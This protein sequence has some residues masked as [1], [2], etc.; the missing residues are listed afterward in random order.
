MQRDVFAMKRLIIQA[1]AWSMLGLIAV[2]TLGPLSYRPR[3]APP[4]L[5]R[6][7]AYFVL[8]A[9]FSVAYDRPR[10]VAVALSIL[11]IGLELG[12]FLAP[13]RDAGLPDAVAK[14][15]GAVAGVAL[16]AVGRAWLTR[17]TTPGDLNLA[18]D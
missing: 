8:G 17:R 14:V 3:M 5:E 18:P 12:Q 9:L 15:L 16:I 1:A 7:G 2:W 4:Q 13:G 11:A 6:F 10:V